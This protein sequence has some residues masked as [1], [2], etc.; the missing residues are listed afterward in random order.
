[1]VENPDILATIARRTANRPPLV[2]GFAAETEH[3]AD[4]AVAKLARKG[5]DW[6]VANDVSP[7]TGIMG[8]DSNAVQIFMKDRATPE[9]WPAMSK[10]NVATRLVARIAETVSPTESI[11]RP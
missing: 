1:M 4:N 6:I 7:T 9:A 11:P 3:V 2:I 8:G 10:D 5:C